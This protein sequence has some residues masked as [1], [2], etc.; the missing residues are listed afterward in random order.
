MF[1]G[2]DK[3]KIWW[4]CTSLLAGGKFQVAELTRSRHPR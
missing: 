3:N 2:W 4:H 1:L